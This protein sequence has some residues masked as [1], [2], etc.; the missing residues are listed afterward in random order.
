MEYLSTEEI[1]E[2][3]GISK[4]RVQ[5]LCVNNRLPG[6]VRFGKMWA[7]PSTLTKPLDARVRNVERQ[8]FP[9]NYETKGARNSLRKVVAKS[10]A[11]LKKTIH[12]DKDVLTVLL[13]IFASELLNNALDDSVDISK[14]SRECFDF[15][16]FSGDY[17][18]IVNPIKN[19]ISDNHNHLDDSLS[20][21]YQL[22][23]K[24]LNDFAYTNTQ[25]FT[26]KYMISILIESMK[27]STDE[28]VLDPACGGGNF[29]I[30][31]F[32]KKANIIGKNNISNISLH[33]ILD[34]LYGYEIDELLACVAS[35]NLKY[36]AITL[37]KDNYNISFETFLSFK[38]NIYTPESESL[39]G[40][41]DYEPDFQIILNVSSGTKKKLT[42]ILF[43]P[44]LIATN[45]PFQTIKGMPENLRY[46]L[47]KHY[48]E[49]KC[50][51][52]NTFIKRIIQ[53]LPNN[54]RAAIV[55]QNS[56]M[57]LDSFVELR[58]HIL[59]NC[60]LKHIWELGSNVFLDLSGE[61][62]N[63]ALVTLKKQKPNIETSF[64]FDM[65]RNKTIA[66]I[67]EIMTSGSNIP[68][69]L[70]Q[71]EIQK[72]YNSGFDVLSTEHLRHLQKECQQYSEFAVPMQGT[73]TGNA[74]ELI[75]YFWKHI[76]DREW[77]LVSKGG[78]YSRFEGLNLYSVKWGANGEYI[79][80]TKGSAIRNSGYFSQ[81]ELVFSDTGTA[82]LNVRLLLPGQIFVASGPGIRISKGNVY[83]H[84]AFLNS[85]F[86]TFFV[87]LLS[88]KF[89]IA[90]GYICRIPTKEEILCSK[91]LENY[92]QHC[93]N[94]K[95]HRLSKRA[96]NF[97]FA[98]IKHIYSS[99]ESAAY[100]W[101]I[102]D[103]ND[104]W[105]Q[106]QNEQNIEDYITNAMELNHSDVKAIDSCLGERMIYGQSD[107]N[108]SV[109]EKEIR[110]ILNASCF[111]KRT[112][113][114]KQY[115]GADGIIEYISQLTSIPCESVFIQL[116][117]HF[118]WFK[119]EYVNLYIHGLIMSAVDYRNS[120][121]DHISVQSIMDA[122][123]I[124]NNTDVD[125][126]CKWCL[127]KFNDVHNCI[128]N[129]NPIVTLNI[130]EQIF[131]AIERS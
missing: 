64:L 6:A 118:E 85:R 101:F 111:P 35:F 52:C 76:N 108:I 13:S 83:S 3:W 44:N 88:P 63:V 79:K 122:V 25:F 92:A 65:L 94:S 28:I 71:C 116:Q 78:G 66:E 124:T 113:A 19:F 74:K 87:R 45:P 93:L 120:S 43:I 9:S 125:L 90:A 54:A 67:E 75:D 100:S 34:T 59:S 117:C 37:L 110:Q 47:Q 104:E 109:F 128:F 32:E 27:I 129:K 40:F 24:A 119:E 10:I 12:N 22:G 57:Y 36:K 91:E 114:K 95:V 82:G 26:E 39:S 99:I 46:F 49:C 18:N 126:F 11:E 5:Y 84:L 50:D 30:Y 130:Q 23:A 121:I 123:R 81:T 4:R 80:A 48:P 21:V 102:E 103:L 60:S 29:L 31:A 61:K 127:N 73:S 98:V 53:I 15:E 14:I 89:T 2:K 105:F 33:R 96:E 72:S 41:L 17:H 8:N 62:S 69:S 56:W 51:M 1:S 107:I 77:V 86:A 106:L 55:T 58:R 97:E 16:F 70:N 131:Y 112:K 7:I 68:I 20:W 42:D 115:T 38:T